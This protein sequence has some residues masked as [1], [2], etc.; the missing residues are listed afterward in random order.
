MIGTGLLVSTQVSTAE[1][2]L[3]QNFYVKKAN[4]IP[5][6]VAII[7]ASHEAET[8]ADPDGVDSTGYATYML[9]YLRQ[10]NQNYSCSLVPVSDEWNQAVGGVGYS[11]IGGAQLDAVIA[12]K[13]D[14]CIVGAIVNSTPWGVS[15]ASDANIATYMGYLKTISNKL[16]AN[17]IVPIHTGFLSGS[18][19]ATQSRVDRVV[20]RW[21]EK[22]GYIFLNIGWGAK[23]PQDGTTPSAY[24][25]THDGSHLNEAGAKRVGLEAA[26]CF[27]GKPRFS[28]WLQV[29]RAD[30]FSAAKLGGNF[31]TGGCG[32]NGAGTADFAS[33]STAGSGT[34]NSFALTTDFPGAWARMQRNATSGEASL[35][36]GTP[37]FSG[38]G[39]TAGSTVL[40]VSYRVKSLTDGTGSAWGVMLQHAGV[41]SEYVT[42]IGF[43]MDVPDPGATYVQDITPDTSS[44]ALNVFFRNLLSAAAATGDCYYGGLGITNLT[45]IDTFLRTNGLL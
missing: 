33:Y 25:Y 40:R 20:A 30:E 10:G 29:H 13:P 34:T 42:G 3:L 12:L 32:V 8:N 24:G 44:T 9:A 19:P 15:E 36:T 5:L 41:A 7:G 37:N 28:P 22:K 23:R 21:C 11:S 14:C 39:V 16:I 35:Y 27:A 26:L 6:T 43:D 1:K 31:V 17:G 38:I 4:G 2:E 18:V 45:E